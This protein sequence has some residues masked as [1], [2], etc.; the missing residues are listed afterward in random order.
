MWQYRPRNRVRSPPPQRFSRGSRFL[1]RRSLPFLGDSP[2][3]L[4][5]T[6]SKDE[7]LTNITIYWVTQTIQSSIYGYLAE[8]RQPSLEP[9]DLVERPVGLALFPRDPLAAFRHGDSRSDR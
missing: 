1:D 6:F 7:L 8:T 9:G 5:A 4:E 3:H 2:R